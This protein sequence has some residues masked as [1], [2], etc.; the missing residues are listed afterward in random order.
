M[1]ER[2]RDHVESALGHRFRDPALLER[3]LTHASLAAERAESN[4]RMEFLGDAVLGLVVC[5]SVYTR[6]PRLL[7]GEMTKIKSLVVSRHCCARV[8][9]DL[10]L[11]AALATGKGMQAAGEVPMSLAAAAIESVIAAVYLDGGFEAAGRLIRRWFDPMI[12]EAASSGHQKNFKSFLQQYAQQ[13]GNHPPAYRVLDEQG[14]DHAKCF[15]VAVEM[16]SRRFPACWGQ[17]KKA[18]EQE[19][20]LAALR[21]LGVLGTDGEVRLDPERTNGAPPHTE[22]PARHAP[23]DV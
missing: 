7:E 15:K 1:D 4:E 17:A 22:S 20:A 3:A 14:P 2:L 12:D 11:D 16:G 21:E 5:E 10:G 13:S 6:Y 23:Q 8:A 18:A 19:A 9:K